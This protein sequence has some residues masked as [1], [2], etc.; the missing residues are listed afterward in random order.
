MSGTF[1]VISNNLED[2]IGKLCGDFVVSLCLLHPSQL[3][4]ICFCEKYPLS[5]VE[6]R[7]FSRMVLYK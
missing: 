7:S 2:F 4:Y 6:D 5:V 3:S 1:I